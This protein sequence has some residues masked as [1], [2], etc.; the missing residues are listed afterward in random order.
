[1]H[2]DI[3]EKK[4]KMDVLKPPLCLNPAC[5]AR[6]KRY[7]ISNCENSDEDT[8]APLLE[9]YRKSKKARYDEPM[10]EAGNMKC[11][12][13]TPASPHSSIFKALFS[14]GGT[15]TDLVADQRADANF[16]S[17]TFEEEIKQNL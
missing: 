4:G 14:K 2:N 10:K 3:R 6:E 13:Q 7:Y 1:M 17:A 15:R 12:E 5:R 9:Q 11:I 8:K 16:I